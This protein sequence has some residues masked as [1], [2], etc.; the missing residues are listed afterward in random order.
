MS[1]L[2]LS[3]SLIQPA[4]VL[5]NGATV[6]CSK[7]GLRDTMVV[8]AVAEGYMPYVTWKAFWDADDEEWVCSGGGYYPDLAD[9]ILDYEERV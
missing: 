9:A 3:Q 1:E 8:L 7:P 2:T 6:I 4:S 5:S